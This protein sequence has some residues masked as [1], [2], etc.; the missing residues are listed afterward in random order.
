MKQFLLAIAGLILITACGSQAKIT[1]VQKGVTLSA[2]QDLSCKGSAFQGNEWYAKGSV[3]SE[4]EFVSF[5]KATKV[6]RSGMNY[7]RN[8][9]GQAVTLTVKEIGGEK[10]RSF[11]TS[12]DHFYF[13]ITDAGK[14]VG[15]GIVPV[16]VFTLGT[17][18]V[19]ITTSTRN[20]MFVL[21]ATLDGKEI[22]MPGGRVFNSTQ[23]LTLE[24]LTP[25]VLRLVI[26]HNVV[27]TTTC[28]NIVVDG[29]MDSQNGIYLK[30]VQT[31][32]NPFLIVNYDVL[33]KEQALVVELMADGSFS[34]ISQSTTQLII[35]E[36]T[37]TICV[38]NCTTTDD[39]NI[40]DGLYGT[41]ARGYRI[42]HTG[43]S[44]ADISDWGQSQF[45]FWCRMQ[46]G[47][48]C[49]FSPS[50]V[51]DSSRNAGTWADANLPG[52]F[53]DSSDDRQFRRTISITTGKKYNIKYC[54]KDASGGPMYFDI[55]STN[56]SGNQ[57]Q[58]SI[59]DLVMSANSLYCDSFT[60]EATATGS[61]YLAGH[62]GSISA[63]N[64][65][66]DD[67]S[68]TEVP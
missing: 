13:E 34:S 25:G 16:E 67:F 65:R 63:G 2:D 35:W 62:I 36:N 50:L 20:E 12:A 48:S 40:V 52:T 26:C 22:L 45:S 4:V 51:N 57:L 61:F 29:K 14:V 66:F 31:T 56:N 7:C 55:V 39:Y 28:N 46:A 24:N 64:I 18:D 42:V 41:H 10:T 1:E 19:S 38:T 9:S 54:V 58:V 3:W 11:T 6:E 15:E 43:A 68:V 44:W 49:G 17:F 5:T 32:N 37:V 8:D 47:G 53:G 27:D 21:V 33:N 30:V 59:Y 60:F 23:G